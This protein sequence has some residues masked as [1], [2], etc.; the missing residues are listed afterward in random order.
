[1]GNIVDV[2][3]SIYRGCKIISYIAGSITASFEME[4]LMKREKCN[5]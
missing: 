5:Q 3:R 2:Y 4:V 1:M